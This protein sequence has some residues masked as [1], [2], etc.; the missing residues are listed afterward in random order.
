MTVLIGLLCK[1]GIVVASDSQE[2]DEIYMKRLGVRKIY[3]TETFGFTDVQLVMGGAGSNAYIRKAVELIREAGYAP[4]FMKPR[5]VANVVEKALGD[6]AKRHG[7]GEDDK[8]LDVGLLLGVWCR[9]APRPEDESDNVDDSPCPYALYSIDPPERGE[10]VGVAD[11]VDDY[12][13]MGSGGLFAQYLLDRLHDDDHKTTALT[14]EEGIVE[15]IY[16]VTVT[17]LTRSICTA[18]ARFTRRTSSPDSMTSS[19]KVP[20]R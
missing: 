5:E 17:R 14:V 2:S 18:A 16:V 19:E 9:N 12:V 15:A 4:F 7:Y 6:M 1:D 20:K 3:D 8:G 13:A 10:R 11:A